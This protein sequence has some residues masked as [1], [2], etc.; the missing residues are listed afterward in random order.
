[1]SDRQYDNRPADC[2]FR[3]HDEGKPYPRSGCTVCGKNIVTGL[4]THC[5]VPA[6]HAATKA[7]TLRTLPIGSIVHT[8][9]EP[10]GTAEPQLNIVDPNHKLRPVDSVEEA[11]TL[12]QEWQRIGAVPGYDPKPVMPLLELDGALRMLARVHLRQDDLAG[13]VV[14]YGATPGMEVD[15]G[16]YMR[17][18]EVVTKAI[19]GRW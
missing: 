6:D 5:T 16:A 18:W 15:Q 8:V 14:R 13:F 11:A 3:L 10:N 4:G 12:H 1:M 7:E 2:R 19:G 17:A 9:K